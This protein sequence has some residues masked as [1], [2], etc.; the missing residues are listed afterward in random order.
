MRAAALI[1][2]VLGVVFAGASAVVLRALDHP[3]KC[4]AGRTCATRKMP[5][6]NAPEATVYSTGLGLSGPIGA[7]YAAG[8]LWIT[9]YATNSVTEFGWRSASD[10]LVH[11]GPEYNFSKPS[12]ITSGLHYVWVANTQ[13]NSVTEL[14]A[15]DGTAVRTIANVASPSAL[16]LSG[17]MLWVANSKANTV[18]GFSIKTGN[19][20]RIIYGDGFRDP[21][22]LAV[23][24]GRLWVANRGTGTISVL[25]ATTGAWRATLR[26]KKLDLR[27]PLTEVA[28]PA[29][30]WVADSRG[31]TEIST[32]TM[33][34]LRRISDPS[35]KLGGRV[36][37][38]LAR[39]DLWVADMYGNSV[40]EIDAANGRLVQVLSGPR[41]H[42]DYPAGIA[43]Y[44]RRIWVTN[45]GNASITELHLP[46]GQ[47]SHPR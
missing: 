30:L 10:P 11:R 5:V 8:R 26:G 35:Y 46:A 4:G 12:A 38:V 7:A 3:V 42:F 9:N 28:G 34:V 39:G 37:M 16:A 19:L 20:V 27:D 24:S 6:K 29:T 32:T 2:S 44:H 22:A 33:H 18:S 23:S 15:A 41:Y 47:S 25:N 40:T 43:A 21:Y 14:N 45:N 17:N 36:A 31:I 1:L 13:A